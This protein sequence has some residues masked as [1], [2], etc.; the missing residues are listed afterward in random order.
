MLQTLPKDPKEL[1]LLVENGHPMTSLRKHTQVN[2]GE[3]LYW[4]AH[5]LPTT[6][7]YFCKAK[8]AHFCYLMHKNILQKLKNA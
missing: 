8:N 3:N 1:H 6:S 5:I 2:L 7:F 4:E